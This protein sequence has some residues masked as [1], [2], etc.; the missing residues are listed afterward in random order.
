[1][2]LG[3]RLTRGHVLRHAPAKGAQGLDAALLDIAQDLLLQDLDERDEIDNLAFKGGTA[4]RKLYAGEAGRFSTDLD[5][6][7]H[8]IEEDRD[9]IEEGLVAAIADTRCGP[10]QYGIT[11]RRGKPSITIESN[12]GNTEALTCKLDVNPPPWLSAELRNWVP[13]PIHK[14]YGSPLPE[15]R[16]VRLEENMAEKIARMNRA[17]PARD[18][19]DLVWIMRNRGRLGREIDLDLIRRL[20]VMKAWVDMNGLGATKHR[21]SQGHDPKPFDADHWL[22]ERNLED[23]DDEN[24]GLLATPPPELDQLGQALSADFQ[25]LRELTP[26]EE[27]LAP[28]SEGDRG[29][30]LRMLGELPLSQLPLGTCW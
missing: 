11:S 17:T 13:M 24:I 7:V 18:A 4:L 28:C 25:F 9:A 1:M 30:L 14:F 6:S 16:V 12:L 19:Y 23:F 26:D 3:V 5:F 29:I 27:T 20:A 2:A 15:L 22:R 21:W 10:F 8:S